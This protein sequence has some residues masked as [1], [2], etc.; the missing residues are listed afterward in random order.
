[1]TGKIIK[2]FLATALLAA[3]VAGQA[4]QAAP[5]GW[6]TAANQ[7]Q[8]APAAPV[9][10]VK[11]KAKASAGGVSTEVLAAVGLGLGGAAIA[12]AAAGGKSDASPR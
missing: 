7:P 4:Q 12:A 2:T 11:A 8:T 10:K 1:M 9:R 6:T 5:A 3:P